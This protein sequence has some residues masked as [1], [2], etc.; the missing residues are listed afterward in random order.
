MAYLFVRSWYKRV[1]IVLA[2]AL[3]ALLSNGLR[4]AIVSLF[5]YFEMRGP[6]GDIHGPFALFRSLMISG[7]GFMVLFGLVFRMGEQNSPFFSRW[8]EK[9]SGRPAAGAPFALQPLSSLVAVILQQNHSH[10]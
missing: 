3:I 1:F 5:A 9:R 2:S 7:V 8:T 6:N 4:V 10:Q